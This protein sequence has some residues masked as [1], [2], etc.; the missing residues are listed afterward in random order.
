MSQE[1]ENYVYL[2]TGSLRDKMYRVA[3][4]YMMPHF[5]DYT[6][7]TPTQI[8]LMAAYDTKL[9]AET[10]VGGSS[11]LSSVFP[12]TVRSQ[13]DYLRN[14]G[15]HEV[16][17]DAV[18]PSLLHELADQAFGLLETP[19]WKRMA[20]PYGDGM[21]FMVEMQMAVFSNGPATQEHGRM[22]LDAAEQ[23]ARR[24]EEIL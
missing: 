2:Y 20:T 15:W 17:A 19:V 18:P 1:N 12:E 8:I 14:L 24:M 10:F 7:G 5:Q 16:R 6:R 3:E 23:R 13:W 21:R 4:I 11:F 9:Q 22:L